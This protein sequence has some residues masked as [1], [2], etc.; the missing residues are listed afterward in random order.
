MFGIF[1]KEKLPTN[2]KRMLSD[3]DIISEVISLDAAHNNLSK[4]E[5]DTFYQ[6]YLTF[7]TSNEKYPTFNKGYNDRIF[8]IGHAFEINGIP[9][10]LISKEDQLIHLNYEQSYKSFDDDIYDLVSEFAKT[11]DSIALDNNIHMGITNAYGCV[12]MRYSFELLKVVNHATCKTQYLN[13]V[14]DGA[15][16]NYISY[17]LKTYRDNDG[18][19]DNMILEFKEQMASQF[20]KVI[21]AHGPMENNLHDYV[22][23][24][25]EDIGTPNDETNREKLDHIIFHWG[26]NASKFTRRY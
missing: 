18:L 11:I 12:F 6:T 26:W 3:H 7:S 23:I 13:T 19:F 2:E 24:L 9:F 15:L 14:F 17:V 22:D 4:E 8:A 21:Y 16:N 5:F 20:Q 10:E 1:N 25:L